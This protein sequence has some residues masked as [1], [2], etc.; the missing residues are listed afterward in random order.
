[1]TNY[2]KTKQFERFY[3]ALGRFQF[4]AF[5]ANFS[6][7]SIKLGSVANYNGINIASCSKNILK[8]HIKQCQGSEF[9]KNPTKNS[10]SAVIQTSSLQNINLSSEVYPNLIN[11]ENSL[12]PY[13]DITSSAINDTHVQLLNKLTLDSFQSVLTLNTTIYSILINLTLLS[14]K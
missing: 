1:V 6:I 10:N 2:L 3:S 8:R 4:D 14:I 9:L 12:Y 7:F 13:G 11:L 5:S